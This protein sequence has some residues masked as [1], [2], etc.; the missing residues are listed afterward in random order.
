M[1]PAE[2]RTLQAEATYADIGSKKYSSVDKG[3]R[4]RRRQKNV[5]FQRVGKKQEPTANCRRPVGGSAVA[6]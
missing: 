5:I 6:D 2:K 3:F 4:K 1:D